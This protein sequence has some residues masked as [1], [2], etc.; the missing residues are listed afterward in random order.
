MRVAVYLLLHVVVLVGYLDRCHLPSIA[1]V[2]PCHAGAE[3]LFALLEAL[4][5]VVADD[6]LQD[7]TL[8]EACHRCEMIEPL[9][10]GC[11]LGSLVGRYHRIVLAGQ[12]QGI[13]HL[14]L[15]CSGVNAQTSDAH[16]SRGSIE[17]LI[18][19][20]AQV[21]AIDGVGPLATKPLHVET[22]GT[23]PY[24][25]VGSEGYAHL[26]VG[27]LRMV[28]KVAHGIDNL[29]NARLVVGTEQSGSVGDYNVLAAVRQQLG[30][31]R[32]REHHTWPQL[33]VAAVVGCHDARLDVAAAGIGAGVAVRNEAYH[34]CFVAAVCWQRGIEI[35]VGG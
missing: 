28:A 6:V 8:H 19:K 10:V 7:G 4:A 11:G 30:K 24:L 1:R 9:P 3:K 15:G 20:L 14:A 2:E 26:P 31:G 32:R 34:G 25:L 12:A 33:D 21:A 22:I 16:K 18:L 29:G 35:A 17:V 5:V 13:Y 27:N 23:A